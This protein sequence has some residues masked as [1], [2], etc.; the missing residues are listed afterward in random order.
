A[1]P[2]QRVPQPLA[3]Q[4]TV[5]ARPPAYAPGPGPQAPRPAFAGRPGGAPPRPPTPPQGVPAVKI[6]E[7]PKRKRG[8]LPW[9]ISWGVIVVAAAVAATLILLNQGRGSKQQAAGKVVAQYH[10]SFSAPTDWTQTGGRANLRE[11]ELKPSDLINGTD[12]ILVQEA[13]LTVDATANHDQWIGSLRSEVAAAGAQYSGFDANV[14]YAGRPVIYYHQTDNADQ[15]DWYALATG[16]IQ[17]NV[18]C[19]YAS[20]PV[21]NRIAAACEQIVR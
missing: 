13:P 20:Q 2:Q 17:V 18:G 3:G 10:Y 21:H 6:T 7:P 8:K 14:S 19:A 9:L 5:R 1:A 11:T 16:K 12:G 4:G 15:I